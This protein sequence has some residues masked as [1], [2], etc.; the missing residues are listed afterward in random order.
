M[1]LDDRI[2]KSIDESKYLNAPN[3]YRYRTILRFLYLEFEKSK[4]FLSKEEIYDYLKKYDDFKNYTVDEC[5]QDLDTLTSWGN[6]SASQTNKG[7]KTISEFQ[8]KRFRY[9]ITRP[10]IEIEKMI[11]KLENLH[12]ETFSL[13]PNLIERITYSIKKIHELD[14]NDIQNNYNWCEDLLNDFKRLNDNYRNYMKEINNNKEVMKT[15]DFMIFKDSLL[16]YLNNFITSLQN[17]ST[18]IEKYLK[19]IDEDKIS[20]I[21]SGIT[22]YDLSISNKEEKNF[23][24]LKKSYLSKFNNI[25]EWFCSLNGNESE[26]TRIEDFTIKTINKI[27]KY[28]VRLSDLGRDTHNRKAE[29]YKIAKMFYDFENIYEAHMLSAYIFGIEKPMKLKFTLDRKTDN[30]ESS[31]FDERPRIIKLKSKN[32]TRREKQNRSVIV[33]KSL[34]KQKAKE[35]YMEKIKEKREILKKYIKNNKLEFANLG[36]IDIKTLDIFLVWLRKSFQNENYS[37]ITEDGEKY[38]LENPAEKN[39]CKIK[40]LQGILDM[41][42]FILS[43][44]KRKI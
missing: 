21:F 2:K 3:T 5:T 30:I 42:A 28:A 6:I 7:F 36:L 19:N 13:E 23:E 35:E 40:T 31:V 25:R 26:V 37:N 12:L 18:R 4:Y 14:I 22:K 9:E 38:I 20:E 29:Y 34:E 33:D 16:K 17:N 24:E 27:T 10:S 44:E 8:N 1:Q 41:P 39:R 43:F 11:I 32:K 15:L